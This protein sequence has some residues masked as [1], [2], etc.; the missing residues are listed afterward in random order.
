MKITFLISS[1]RPLQW[2][3]NLIIFAALIFSKNLFN[4]DAFSHSLLAF[5]L[6]CLI[7]GSIYIINDIRDIAQ[8]RLHPEK[9][10]RAIASGMI[11]IKEA[12]ILSLSIIILAIPASFLLNFGFGIAASIYILI[13]ILYSLHLKRIFILDV[14]IISLGFVIRAVAGALVIE[15]TISSWLLVCTTFLALFIASGKRYHELLLLS[16]DK[17]YHRAQLAYYTPRLLDQ[18]ISIATAATIISYALYTMSEETIAKFGSLLILTLPFVLYGILRYLYLIYK[19]G[20]GGNPSKILIKDKPLLIN[21]ALW[22]IT[23]GIIIYL[24]V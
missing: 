6:F 7:S 21:I 17:S 20:L 18:I 19:E 16:E 14:L 2:S 12:L 22:I 23:A 10:K 11:S 9:S 24:K 1:L 4:S 15:V 8:D 13:M 5:A 3:K